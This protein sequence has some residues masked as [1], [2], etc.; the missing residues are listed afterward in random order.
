MVTFYADQ[1]VIPPGLVFTADAGPDGAF[2]IKWA[3]KDGIPAGKYRIA[4]AL[5]DAKGKDK[6]QGAFSAASTP[7]VRD[8]SGDTADV[9]LDIGRH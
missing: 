2:E 9:T 1:G 7:F 8:V 5:L 4:V 6:L 3:D